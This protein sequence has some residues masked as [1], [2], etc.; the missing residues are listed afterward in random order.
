MIRQHRHLDPSQHCHQGRLLESLSE[1]IKIAL[2]REEKR[3]YLVEQNTTTPLNFRRRRRRLSSLVAK[4]LWEAARFL[5]MQCRSCCSCTASLIGD[6]VFIIILD[7]LA[8]VIIEVSTTVR[9]CPT[10]D[11]AATDSLSSLGDAPSRF[12]LLAT[13]VISSGGGNDAPRADS[14]GH[15]DLN[16]IRNENK[17]QQ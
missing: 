5:L 2:P 15:E 10:T 9:A 12:P 4:S 7:S 3:S 6:A 1:S 16:E 14:G 13:R 17:E 11:M 8:V